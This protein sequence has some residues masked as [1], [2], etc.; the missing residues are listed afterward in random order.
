MFC[1]DWSTVT[2]A[3][4]RAE[5]MAAARNAVRIKVA[6]S[7]AFLIIIMALEIINPFP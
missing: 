2:A 3:A 5:S 6:H 1:W 7:I 4:G